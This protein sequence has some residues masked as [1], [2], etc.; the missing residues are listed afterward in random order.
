MKDS[1]DQMALTLAKATWQNQQIPVISNTIAEAVSDSSK[2]ADL[3]ERQ[4][5]S[6]VRW[7]ESMKVLG[8][9]PEIELAFEFGSGEVLT[10]LM[11]RINKELPSMGIND[12]A[13]VAAA[14]ERIN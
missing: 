14:K 4:L 10:G 9:V 3:L 12:S 7:T 5:A 6:S 8:E 2:W 1:A 11:K 13:T